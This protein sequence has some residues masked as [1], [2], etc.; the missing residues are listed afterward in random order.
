[1]RLDCPDHKESDSATIYVRPHELEISRSANGVPS[2][3]AWVTHLNPV[4]SLTK[5]HL[6]AQEFDT[7]IQVEVSPAKYKQLDLKIGDSVHLFP[8]NARVFAP[9]YCI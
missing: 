6:K 5:V 1:M 8:K 4:G 3:K 9:D 7:L 2:L